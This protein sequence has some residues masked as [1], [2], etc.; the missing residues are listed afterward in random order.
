M[1]HSP[2]IDI[3]KCHIRNPNMAVIS[4]SKSKKRIRRDADK[5]HPFEDITPMNSD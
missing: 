1:K 3:L 2:L 4:Q 5:S